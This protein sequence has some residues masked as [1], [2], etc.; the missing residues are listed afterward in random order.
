MK[1]VCKDLSR[2]VF[3]P[4][5]TMHRM[6]LRYLYSIKEHNQNFLASFSGWVLV[7][8]FDTTA[9]LLC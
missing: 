5:L 9:N 6:D 4:T 2:Y 7:V 1:R 8:V 3:G